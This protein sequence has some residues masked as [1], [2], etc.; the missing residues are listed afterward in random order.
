[1]LR[2]TSYGGD[3]VVWICLGREAFAAGRMAILGCRQ[4][5][6]TGFSA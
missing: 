1:M 2:G 4:Q 6:L 5:A 3:P